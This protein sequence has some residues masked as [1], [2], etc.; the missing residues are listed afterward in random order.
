M[1]MVLIIVGLI[2]V[3]ARYKHRD[4]TFENEWRKKPI[5]HRFK[6][7]LIFTGSY[8]AGLIFLI[9]TGLWLPVLC[10]GGIIVIIT[11]I[12]IAIKSFWDIL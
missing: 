7:A 11:L 12:A 5:G 1:F 8:L 10:I 3:L 9:I 2:I 6:W 4:R